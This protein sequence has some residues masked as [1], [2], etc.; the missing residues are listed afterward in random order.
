MGSLHVGAGCSRIDAKVAAGR[1][2]PADNLLTFCLTFLKSSTFKR[3]SLLMVYSL[4]TADSRRRA[5]VSEHG[6]T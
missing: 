5:C 6:S 2:T 3:G 4:W 1:R